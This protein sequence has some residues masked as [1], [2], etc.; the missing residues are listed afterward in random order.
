MHYKELENIKKKKL[1]INR[2]LPNIFIYLFFFIFIFLYNVL[3]V[4]YNLVNS[5]TCSYWG[6][7]L[8]ILLGKMC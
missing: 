1:L 3:F 8:P 6:L 2:K 5:L 7:L 4:S